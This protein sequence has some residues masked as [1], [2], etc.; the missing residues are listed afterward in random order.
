MIDLNIPL[1]R[2]ID[3]ICLGRAGVDLYA[4]EADTDLMDVSGFE[5]YVGGSP[6]NIAVAL[7]KLGAKPG[8]ISS[9]SDDGLGKFVCTYLESMGVDLQG[10]AVDKSG[11]R[12]SLAITEMKAYDCEVVIYRNNA[13]DLSLNAKQIDP[14][15]IASAKA[16]IVTGTALSSSPSREATLLAIDYARRAGTLVVLD[17][18]YRAYSWNSPEDSALYYQLA[19]SLSD[20]VI[21]NR[22]EFDV[23]EYMVDRGN[24]DDGKTAARYLIESTQV[25][26]I[27]A[28]ELGS[29]VYTRDGNYFEHGIFPVTVKKPFGAGDS[30]AGALVYALLNGYGLKTVVKMGSAAAAINVSSDSCTEAMPTLKELQDFIAK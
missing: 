29:K 17:I 25:V 9:V 21:G 30:F 20:I 2:P 14:A 28:G 18:D 4:R 23:M 15:Y 10:V 8:L 13:A 1:D 22:E 5:K 3:A 24:K 7:A 12:T 19:A 6:A 11:S 26:V 16:L 27:K